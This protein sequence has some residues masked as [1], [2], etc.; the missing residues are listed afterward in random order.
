VCYSIIKWKYSLHCCFEEDILDVIII[1]QYKKIRGKESNEHIDVQKYREE[2]RN[3]GYIFGSIVSGVATLPRG[4]TGC[5]TL[6]V[7][8]NVYVP[9]T[10][11]R[12]S[13]LTLFTHSAIPTPENPSRP[14]LNHTLFV[15]RQPRSHTIGAR[16]R[17][18]SSE[19]TRP[20]RPW[21]HSGPSQPHIPPSPRP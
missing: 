9:S 3:N 10:I 15:S 19:K 17:C 7:Q 6:S 21:R 14:S 5:L 8:L 20:A 12:F 11:L 16:K 1:I 18:P 13:Y 2:G 4:C